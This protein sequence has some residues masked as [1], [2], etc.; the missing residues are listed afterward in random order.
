MKSGF[1]HSLGSRK[2]LCQNIK[3]EMNSLKKNNV[4]KVGSDRKP[5]MIYTAFMKQELQI[6]T[7]L[8][9]S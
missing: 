4:S 9:R 5:K 1:K 3:K 6:K 8:N 7:Q 2:R